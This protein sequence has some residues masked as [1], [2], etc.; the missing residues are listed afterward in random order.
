MEESERQLE[1]LQSKQERLQHLVPQIQQVRFHVVSQF[2]HITY[3]LNLGD[4][5]SQV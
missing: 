3:F 1:E 2:I 5:P 4:S